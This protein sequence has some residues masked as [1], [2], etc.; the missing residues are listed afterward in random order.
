M[1]KTPQVKSKARQIFS[2][3]LGSVDYLSHLKCRTKNLDVFKRL[4]D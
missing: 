2:E 1:L 3:R 4:I